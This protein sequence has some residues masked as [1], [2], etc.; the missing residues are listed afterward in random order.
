MHTKQ[1]SMCLCY[2]LA[3]KIYSVMLLSYSDVEAFAYHCFSPVVC[4]PKPVQVGKLAKFLKNFP[5]AA[6]P[7]LE[8]VKCNNWTYYLLIFPYELFN[9]FLSCFYICIFSVSVDFSCYSVLSTPCFLPVSKIQET[10]R[11]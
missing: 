8:T 3:V 10:K 7:T 6:K 9:S 1:A 11:M 4:R 2:F 5:E